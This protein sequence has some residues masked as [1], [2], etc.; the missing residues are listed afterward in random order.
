MR[1]IIVIPAVFIG[2]LVVVWVGTVAAA[3]MPSQELLAPTLTA[4]AETAYIDVENRDQPGQEA[5]QNH[6][7]GTVNCSLSSAYPGNIQQWCRLI[8]TAAQETGLPASLIAAV[9][10]QESGGDPL[11]TSSSGAVGLMQVMPRDGIAAEFICVNGPCFASRPTMEEL[12][13]PAYNVNYGS[14]MLAGLYAKYGS[15]RD[16]LFHYG[17]MD[18]GYYYAD[19]VLR[20]WETYT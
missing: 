9:M 8:E 2:C 16:A 18:M 11:I 5:I 13:D 19:L 1:R 17:P 12:H 3:N 20:I 4:V 10:L 6:L 14:Q 15:Y 7:E